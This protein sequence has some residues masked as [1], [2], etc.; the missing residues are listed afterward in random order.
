MPLNFVFNA[1]RAALV[2]ALLSGL[3]A[4]AL[5]QQLSENWNTAACDFTDVAT[6]A[7]ARPTNLQRVDIWYRWAANETSV[8]YSV[9]QDG[10]AVAEGDLTR[11]EC[12]PYQT[13]WCVARVEP[14]ADLQPGTY[15]FR[16]AHARI[17]QN[18]GSR[19]QGFIRAFG[20]SR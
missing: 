9:S 8:H 1:G 18:A 11:A 2:G 19:G 7:L 3:T 4:P 17:C 12:D 10:A 15:V 6:L 20:T 14:G 16:T 5:A 13:A